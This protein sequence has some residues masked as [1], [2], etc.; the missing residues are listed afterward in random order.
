M[1]PPIVDVPYRRLIRDSG[2][3]TY[4]LETL[5]AVTDLFPIQITV[6]QIDEIYQ[7]DLIFR[8]L[9][10]PDIIE[11]FVM[12][13]EV[14]ESLATFGVHSIIGNKFNCAY[15]SEDLP[16]EMLDAVVAFAERRSMLGW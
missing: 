1:F 16:Q 4:K 12:V 11:P 5:P 13:L 10:D 3:E 6:A 2:T 8:I 7:G 15:Y 9:L 14:K